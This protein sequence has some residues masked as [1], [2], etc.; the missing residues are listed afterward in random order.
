MY[1]WGKQHG[2]EPVVWVNGAPTPAAA[3]AGGGVL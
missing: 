2:W 3:A 1:G